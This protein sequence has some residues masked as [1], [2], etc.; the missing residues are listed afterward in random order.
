MAP[1][2]PD[3]P[4]AELKQLS[5]ELMRAIDIRNKARSGEGDIVAAQATLLETILRI[6]NESE[7]LAGL[8]PDD[9]RIQGL[10]DTLSEIPKGHA[11]AAAVDRL[12]ARLR[13]ALVGAAQTTTNSQAEFFDTTPEI[14]EPASRGAMDRPLQTDPIWTTKVTPKGPIPVTRLSGEVVWIDP[15]APHE[16]DDAVLTP[17]DE[18]HIADVTLS[19][20]SKL[21]SECD[22]L[23]S[24]A[25]WPPANVI[26]EPFRRYAIEI[27]DVNAAA[28]RNAAV[29]QGR[30]SQ[31][32]LTALLHN[33]LSNLFGSEWE[34]SPG[35]GLT[36]TDRQLGIEGLKVSEVVA[37][38]GND[39]DPQC[40]YHRLLSDAIMYRYR[41]H[42]LLPDPIPGEPPDINLSNLEWWRYIG[43][44]ERHDLAM[45][46]KP[47]LEDRKAYWQC[48]YGTHTPELPAAPASSKTVTGGGPEESVFQ[49]TALSPQ[50]EPFRSRGRGVKLE[51]G[52]EGQVAQETKDSVSPDIVAEPGNPEDRLRSFLG[53]HPG[54]TLADIKHSAGV[55]T[56]DFQRWRR[57]RLKQDSVMSERIEDV[58]NGTTQLKK[59]P[60]KKRL[61]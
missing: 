10:R 21:R 6:R 61:D 28:Y 35:E 38:A 2:N 23:F 12:A 45:A 29:T 54:T 56:P 49:A 33:L 37:I 60:P 4:Y 57:G 25:D 31:Q 11:P 15:T 50:A 34:S 7:Y 53:S 19:E 46:I 47:Y 52:V 13:G 48:V 43:L 9:R 24:G 3:D 55:F 39:P 27:F 1:H 20:R 44:H 22:R 8:N 14:I 32:V 5:A 58:L 42:D 51:H 17:G 16:P 59:N 18:Q 41:F 26:V 40:L 36:R 30:D